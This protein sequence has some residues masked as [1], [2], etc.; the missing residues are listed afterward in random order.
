MGLL[1]S[2]ACDQLARQREAALKQQLFDALEHFAKLPKK[3][4]QAML[5]A[6]RKSWV[7]GELM[8]AHPEM[9]REEA[10][11]IYDRVV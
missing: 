8:L 11:Q 5:A 10:E 7:I 1:G 2:F 3:E 6:Q 9:T 4:K